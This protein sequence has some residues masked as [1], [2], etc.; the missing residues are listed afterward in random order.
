M[1]SATTTTEDR[2]LALM[3]KAKTAAIDALARYK[4][5][6]FGY[7]ASQWIMLNKVLTKPQPNPFRSLVKH[8]RQMRESPQRPTPEQN[9][10]QTSERSANCTITLLEM[11]QDSGAPSFSDWTGAMQYEEA[12]NIWEFLQRPDGFSHG[13]SGIAMIGYNFRFAEEHGA[14]ILRGTAHPAWETSRGDLHTIAETV[15]ATASFS[16]VPDDPATTAWALEQICLQ[17]PS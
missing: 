17:D 14:I 2:V 12:D 13:Y 10:S 7:H 4:P 8:A 15:L 11:S 5:E 16:V 1:T 3:Q 6:R 9:E